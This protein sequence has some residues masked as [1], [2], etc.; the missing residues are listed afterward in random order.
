MGIPDDMKEDIFLKG[1]KQDESFSGMGLG[2][3]LVKRILESFKGHIWVEDRIKGEYNKGSKFILL[4][5]VV[6]VHTF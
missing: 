6:Y 2:L 4:M 5:P 1:Y 3:Y